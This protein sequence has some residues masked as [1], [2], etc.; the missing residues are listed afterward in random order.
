M[1]N[2]SKRIP[3]EDCV[4]AIEQLNN[5]ESIVIFTSQ[6]EIIIEF[7][8]GKYYIA[9][10][11]QIICIAQEHKA[12]LIANINQYFITAED[13]DTSDET[14]NILTSSI[15]TIINLEEI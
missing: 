2:R 9:D 7:K 14:D 12:S 10:S 1:L 13:I 4:D 3:Y 8:D 5:K 15:L 6:Y 11:H